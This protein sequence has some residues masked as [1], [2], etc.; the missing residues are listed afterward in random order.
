[1]RRLLLPVFIFFTAIASAQQN[2]VWTLQRAIQYAID[3]NLTIQQNVLNARLAKLTM[4]QSQLSQI[5]NLN[6]SGSYGRSYGRSVDPT[7]N[8]FVSGASYD[9]MGLNANADVLVFGWF[10]K[11]NNIAR[12][13]YNYLASEADADQARNDISLNVATGYLRALLAQEQISVSQ[14]Q[15]ELSKAQMSQTLEFAKTGRVPELNVAQ[16]ESQLANDSA[17]LITAI[18]DYTSAILDIKALLNLDFTTPFS[19]EVP[20]VELTDKSAVLTMSPEEIYAV[21]SK[22]YGTIRSSN[23]RLKAAQKGLGA[24][25][26]ALLPQLGLSGTLGTNWASTLK[27]YTGFNVT[28]IKPTGAF[29][30]VGDTMVNVYQY[31]GTYTTRNV[32]LGKQLNN[33]FRQTIS[34]NLTVPLFNGW[35]AQY[36]VKQ[37]RINMLTSELNKDQAELKLRQDI[38]KAY[39]DAKNSIQKYYAAERAAESAARALDF[40]QKR[41]DLGLTN[42]VD[43]L[44]TKNTSYT[45]SS[46]LAKAKYDL[47]FKLKVIDYYLGKE[48]KL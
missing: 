46:N 45:A 32:P 26:G 39:N 9:F 7:T 28:G 2:E 13:K 12:N 35:Q 1:M 37:A 42:T 11:R 18:T 48:I 41:Y 47:I 36:N 8:Q 21:S 17:N 38:Y 4:Q 22:T 15:V 33:N 27:E 5:P 14:K 31:D 3:H 30:P 10:Q 34:M 23:Y 43:Y 25:K 24:S 19:L 40:A 44:T 6:A 16:M 20:T 29:I